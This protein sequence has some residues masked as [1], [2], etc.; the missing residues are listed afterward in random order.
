MAVAS[1]LD[2]GRNS[3]VKRIAVSALDRK[4]LFLNH[5]A[6]FAIGRRI[7]ILLLIA[8]LSF[9]TVY[10]LAMLL[11]GSLHSTPPGMPG[12]LNLDGYAQIFTTSNFL[13]LA[14]TIGISFAKTIPSILLA[15]AL[16]FILART[17]TPAR[18]ALEVLV[19][20]PFFIPPILTAMAWHARQPAGRRAQPGLEMADRRH[21][22]ADQRLLVRRC[23]LAHDAV[24]DAVPVSVHRRCLPRHGSGA[25]GIEPDV[26][27]LALAH[28][29]PHH[30]DPDAAGDCLIVRAQPDPRH[31]IIRIAAVLRLARRHHR[32]H[33][34]D[35]QRHQSPGDTGLSVRNGTE[36]RHHG[37]HVPVRG[38]AVAGP[39]RPQLRNRHRQGLCA[40]CDETRTLALGHV[41]LLC[42]VFHH[43]GGAAGRPAANRLVLQVLPLLRMG[44]A[45]AR[46]LRGGLQKQGVLARL[47]QYHAAWRN[48]RLRHHDARWGCRLC[49]GA[50]ALA[51]AAADR[52]AGLVAMDDAG[53]G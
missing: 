4:T 46:T 32:D 12:V 39:A 8:L 29:P 2:I 17:D 38:V 36:L 9:L 47:R 5:L 14:N 6:N 27:R 50:H 34:R 33:H 28:V 51:R 41:R 18:G 35:L 44:H 26:R 15:V 48:R 52:R 49:D 23:R 21:H 13:V 42:A 24:L 40:Q 45:R 31:R 20:L 37:V 1:G 7:G 3:T 53:N 19:T 16:A 30:P 10:P 11:Y 43:H 22:V 25:R